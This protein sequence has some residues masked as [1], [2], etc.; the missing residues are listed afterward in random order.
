M[1]EKYKEEQPYFYDETT[2]N[3]KNK[4]ISHAYLIETR[5]YENRDSIILS[6]V[7]EL[8]FCSNYFDK[9]GYS[10]E[11]IS[12]LIDDNI[13]SDFKIIEPDGS[14]I[15]K[16][17]ISEIKEQ[18]KTTS[19][20]NFSRIYLIRDAGSL[21]KQAANSLLKFLE[22]PEGNVIALLE[23]DNRYKVLETIR[24][25]CQIYTLMNLEQEKTYHYL[26][27]L[28][29]LITILEKRKNRAIAYLPMIIEKDNRNKDE[30][31]LIFDEMLSIYELALRKLLKV[32]ILVS[33]EINELLDIIISSNN[34]NS[35]IYKI[36]VLYQV[37]QDL[38]YNLNFNLMLD[39]F[40]IKFNGGENYE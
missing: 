10:K 19:V 32:K 9:S 1:L 23:V 31:K 2:R 6:F 38:E 20:N 34:Q 13:F 4:K 18:F 11:E 27:F 8:F 12:K 29:D 16:D 40:I 24:S 26:E 36:S 17:Q 33:G 7:K 21:N 39:H 5:N 30:W 3:I 15:K 22:E 35:I 28:I 37:I 14:W 25:R